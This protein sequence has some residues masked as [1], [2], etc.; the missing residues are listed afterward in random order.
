MALSSALGA[1]AS[2]L[3]ATGRRIETVGNNVANAATEG[4]A[5]REVRLQPNATAPGVQVV[6]VN[7]MVD[8]FRLADRRSAGA[9]SAATDLVA[10]QLQRIE[11]AFGAPGVAGSLQSGLDTFDAALLAA[12]SEPDSPGRLAAV[13]D[14]ARDLATRFTT[15]SDTIQQVR[16]ET[17]R[18]IGDMVDRLNA[19]LE[20]VAKLDQKIAAARATGEDAAP[21]EDHRQK[22]VDRVSSLIPLREF[23]R[24]N[25]QTALVAVNGALLLDGSPARFGFTTAPLITASST[26][27]LSG[28]TMNGRVMAVGPGSLIDGGTLS[29]A[30]HLRDTVTPKVQSDLDQ[31]ALS[32]SQRLAAAD[33]TLSTTDAGLFT[34]VGGRADPVNLAGL[35]S[36]LSV[37]PLV[38]PRQGGN[39]ATLRDGLA[40]TTPRDP[41]DGG[42]LSALSAA[43]S[44]ATPRS[45]MGEAALTFDTLATARL[46][47]D[48]A[49]SS[50]AA[51]RSALAESASP[52]AVNT[53]Q[54]L[55]DLL[56]IEQAY[57]AN[58]R[59]ISVVDQMLRTLLEV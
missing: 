34:D 29:A 54:E 21:L 14:T 40:A 51:R 49:A 37:N 38:D 52:D 18:S 6:S 26:A 53:D 2:G 5:R 36:R 45:L 17:D 50:A 9:E 43:L 33:P 15:I 56:Q 22:L 48:T 16:A 30:F 59:V 7:R 10:N 11:N 19:D 4:Y 41:G 39:P 27:P 31:L 20:R 28:L 58:A 55:Q 8:T 13:V 44:A 25:G 42:L 35:S 32:L 1:A 23:P 12:A 24:A 57:A 47:A 3:A 46:A